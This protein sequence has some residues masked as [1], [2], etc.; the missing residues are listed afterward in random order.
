MA[1]KLKN[2]K[3]L[4]VDDNPQAIKILNMVLTSAG[5]H[6]IF[7]APDG[8]AAQEFLDVVDERID[9][10]ICD[11]EIPRMTGLELLQQ[12]RMSH[13]D[14]PFMM[15]TGHTEVESVKAAKEFGVNAYI[16]K[17]YSPQQMEDK[18][19]VLTRNL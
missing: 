17:P 5:V 8:R 3:V 2:L 13:P 11:W 16:G 4:I 15:V 18:L 9:V 14:M 6:Q 10:I 19:K 7:S 12:V 1:I